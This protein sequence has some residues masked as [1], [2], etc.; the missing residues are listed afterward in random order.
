M[1]TYHTEGFFNI[2]NALCN[3]RKV[4]MIVITLLFCWAF[5]GLVF[6]IYDKSKPS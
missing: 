3:I 2:R 4:V 5:F 1:A 6:G